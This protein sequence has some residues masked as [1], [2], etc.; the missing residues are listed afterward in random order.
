MHMNRKHIEVVAAV[1]KYNDLYL[2]VQRPHK[3]EV[4]GKW[5][6]PGGKI[7]PGETQQASLTR[8]IKEELSLEL[9]TM[10][11]LSSHNHSYQS[12]D[13]SIHFYVCPIAHQDIELKEHIDFQWLQKSQLKFVDFAD[14]DKPIISLI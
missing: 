8:E 6:F 7:E 5:E 9:T 13:L 4:G 11:Y 2:V 1:I 10:T 12:F 14:A 3:G